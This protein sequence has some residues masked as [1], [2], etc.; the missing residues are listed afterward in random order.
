MLLIEL[1]YQRCV[2]VLLDLL[3]GCH[4]EPSRIACLTYLLLIFGSS[5]WVSGRP[6]TVVWRFRCVWFLSRCD[7]SPPCPPITLQDKGWERCSSWVLF[8]FP[9]IGHL[10]LSLSSFALLAIC[11][12]RGGWETMPWPTDLEL[13]GSV[14]LESRGR[15]QGWQP[16]ENKGNLTLQHSGCKQ[17]FS[18]NASVIFL[19]PAKLNSWTLLLPFTLSSSLL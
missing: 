15:F 17:D 19:L 7:G 11:A 3:P 16:S 4:V 12:L 9:D 2:R 14:L 13:V 6:W 10:S 18:L 1:A 5:S 8:F